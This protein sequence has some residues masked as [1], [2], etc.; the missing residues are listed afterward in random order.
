MSVRRAV[1]TG[2]VPA[3]L[4]L[5]ALA[6]TACGKRGDP[7]PPLRPIPGRVAD[8]S[9]HRV[10]DRVELR[11]TVPA[12]NLDGYDANGSQHAHGTDAAC[13]VPTRSG[14]GSPHRFG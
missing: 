6:A 3:A 11:F 8:L 7:Q 5:T 2:I 13:S 1:R 9:A 14:T 10:D 12:A 4:V